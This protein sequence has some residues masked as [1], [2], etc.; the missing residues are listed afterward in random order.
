MMKKLFYFT[1]LLVCVACS[2]ENKGED[3]PP[4]SEDERLALAEGNKVDVLTSPLETV[5]GTGNQFITGRKWMDANGE[6]I[7]LFTF[8]EEPEADVDGNEGMSRSFYAEH[9]ARKGDG[10]FQQIRK[11]QDFEK[12]CSFD[13]ML[14]LLD[15]SINITDLDEDKYKEISFAYTL[16]CV[17]DVSPYPMKLMMIENGEKY[18]I[19][20]STR[21]AYQVKEGLPEGAEIPESTDKTFDES[22]DNAPESFKKFASELWDAH[23]LK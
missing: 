4:M 20:G 8:S 21:Y 5:V 16:G 13:N 14:Y 7:L 22:F 11:I 23:E 15:K 1:A 9:F 17:S 19:R 10:D 3:E 18:A 12:G 6:N 2:S